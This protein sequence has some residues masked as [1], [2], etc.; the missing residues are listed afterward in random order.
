MTSFV[1]PTRSALVP[2]IGNPVVPVA[3]TDPPAPHPHMIVAAVVPI[4]WRPNEARARRRH[5]FNAQ[6]RW[7]NVNI[8]GD[9]G[10]CNR[11]YGH[12]TRSHAQTQQ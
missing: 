8:N 3:L 2:T 12:R 4:A 7:C 10:R 5:P 9:S 1:V 6:R 11:G